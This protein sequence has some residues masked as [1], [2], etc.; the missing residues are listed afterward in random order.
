MPGDRAETLPA[1]LAHWQDDPV[2]T[3]SWSLVS[4]EKGVVELVGD[5]KWTF[6][7][8]QGDEFTLG[9]DEPNVSRSA[10]TIRD[11]GPGPIVFRG[12]RD[13]GSQVGVL[14]GTGETV[15]LA[16]GT[17]YNLTSEAHSIEFYNGEELFLTI[18]VD[19]DARAS[20]VERQQ[21]A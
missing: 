8:T 11:S 3:V 10:L 21:Q 5:Q 15:W 7:R 12:Q 1:G 4:G 19:F 6:G 20:V 9:T 2:I 16:E 14:L 17:A 18:N 13:N